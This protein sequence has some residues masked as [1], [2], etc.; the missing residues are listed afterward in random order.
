MTQKSVIQN[1]VIQD[2]KIQIK[3][4]DEKIN[5]M[6]N[7]INVAEKEIKDSRQQIEN[8][9]A[10]DS[11]CISEIGN[12]KTEIHEMNFKLKE[13][14]HISKGLKNTVEH[15][16]V[17]NLELETENLNLHGKLETIKMEKNKVEKIIGEL[18]VALETKEPLVDEIT[19]IEMS[20]TYTQCD[21]KPELEKA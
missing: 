8:M 9:L 14:E 11:T 1:N 3:E 20:D 17:I 5:A 18:E 6:S 19:T 21:E 4:K 15:S 12:L 2:F 10:E 7:E 13:K 16:E